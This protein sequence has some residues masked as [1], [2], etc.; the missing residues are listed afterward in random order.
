MFRINSCGPEDSPLAMFTVSSVDG[1]RTLW[2]HKRRL[3]DFM[4]YEVGKHMNCSFN[5]FINQPRDYVL[6]V[7]KILKMKIDKANMDAALMKDKLKNKG[8]G[9]FNENDLFG[10]LGR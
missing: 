5:E 1:L 4:L 7:L 9:E 2:P 8:K 6:D 3:H 10:S